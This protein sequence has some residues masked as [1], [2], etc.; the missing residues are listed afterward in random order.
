MSKDV[1]AKTMT[2]TLADELDNL[3]DISIEIASNKRM[4]KD[5]IKPFKLTFKD[6]DMEKK[7]SLL[8]FKKTAK[9]IYVPLFQYGH[10]K[11]YTFKSSLFCVFGV[12]V[13]V[14]A[15]E[16]FQIGLQREWLAISYFFSYFF[17]P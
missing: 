11:D 7:V 15:S 8:F 4:K 3:M 1:A 14:F 16:V 12:W 9:S 13:L 17:L 6:K 10:Q 2:A 5:Y